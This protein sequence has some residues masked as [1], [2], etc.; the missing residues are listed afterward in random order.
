MAYHIA[1]G[2]LLHETH[3]FAPTPTTLEDFRTTW[4][5][6]PDLLANLRGTETGVGGM[7]EG[8]EGRAGSQSPPSTRRPCRP[9]RLRSPPTRP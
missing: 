7:I 6:G 8:L 3:T 4:H 5:A 9:G 1:V 2:G